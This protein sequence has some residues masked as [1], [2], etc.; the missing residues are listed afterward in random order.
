MPPRT[1]DSFGVLQGDGHS[2]DNVYRQQKRSR[3]PSSRSLEL[4][5][6]YG[7]DPCPPLPRRN[8][9]A[10]DTTESG[11]EMR[12]P[13]HSSRERSLWQRL[14]RRMLPSE[15]VPPRPPAHPGSSRKQSSLKTFPQQEQQHPQRRHQTW[16]YSSN[17]VLVNRERLEHGLPPLKRSIALDEKA[18]EV[19]EW[20]AAGNDLQDMIPDEN[21]RTFASGNVLVGDSIR[22]I[23]GQILVRDACQRERHNILNPD[24]TEFGMGTF[25]DPKSGLL[26]LCQLFGTGQATTA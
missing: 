8:I 22:E 19:A 17:H 9:T 1:R 2:Q 3:H 12:Q 7:A 11:R 20:A 10:I 6:D 5:A 14:S 26:F 4:G 13:L 23:H 15:S 16:Y 25:K 18:R 21:V 24:Y